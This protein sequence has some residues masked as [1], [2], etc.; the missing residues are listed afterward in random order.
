MTRLLIGGY[1]GTKGKGTGI[2]VLDGDRV[3]ATV[4]AD[5]PSWLARHPR[6]PVLYAVAETDDGRVCGDRKSVV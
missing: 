2:S 3:V 4:P 5:S 1:S 6:L